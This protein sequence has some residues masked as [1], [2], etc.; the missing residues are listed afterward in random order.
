M[1]SLGIFLLLLLLVGCGG[2]P[3]QVAPVSG[4][5]TL[6]GK[7]LSSASVTF[8]PIGEGKMNPGPGSGAFTDSDGRYTLKL[9]GT[10]TSGAVVGKHTV[11]IRIVHAENTADDRPKKFKQLPDKYNRRTKL[12]FEVPVGGTNSADFQLTSP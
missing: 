10:E 11:M 9:T 7:P 2:G 5:V 4:R 12:E 6:N 3:Y 1:R 8:Q